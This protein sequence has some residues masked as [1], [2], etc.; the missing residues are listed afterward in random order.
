[1]AAITAVIFDLDD[2]LYDCTGVLV[3]AARRRAAEAMVK[4]GLPMTVEQAYQL[5]VKL[6]SEYGPRLNVFE[7]IAEI[8]EKDEYLVRV[9]LEAYNSSEISHDIKPFPDVIPTL[10][11]LRA[12]GY[13]LFIITSGVYSRQKRK[14]DILGLW[15]YVDDVLIN[16]LERGT[17]YEECFHEIL[18]KHHLMSK[19]VVCVGDRLHEEIRTGN[20]LGMTTVQMMHGRFRDVA[21]QSPV[22]EPDFRI[23]RISELPAILKRINRARSHE[24]YRV[25]AIGGGTGLPVVLQGLKHRTKNLTALVTV[26]DSGR[27]SGRLRKEMGVLPPGDIRN[28]LVALSQNEQSQK[29]LHDLFQ[30]RFRNG[31][32]EG[33]SLGNLFL[34]ALSE[35][36]GSF[37]KAVKEAGEI[38][39]IQGK[40]L[41]ST[42]RDCHVCAIL[43]DG[44]EV[45]EEFNVRQPGKP[46]IKRVFLEPEDAEALPEAVDEV[47]EADVIVLG[48]G[49]L[50]TSVISNLL[51]KGIPE[52]I[53]DSNAKVIYV[54]NIVTQPGQTD[55]YK[56]SD[57]VKAV[58]DYLHPAELDLVLVN[59]KIPPR[60]VI[61]RYRSEGAELVEIDEDLFRLDVRVVTADL[62]EN[63]QG[64][65]I[66]WEKADLLRHDPEKLAELI[67]KIEGE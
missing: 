53:R 7:K 16:D 26:T 5:Q 64:F 17:S 46:P 48:P 55:G 11:K 28:C 31:S 33:M 44:R 41:P 13:K 65:R 62:I 57:H 30:F 42:L 54:C 9:A 3:D 43:S 51:V 45:R 8:Y 60:E 36:T 20:H 18:L 52:A 1:M 27:S 22:E 56:A 50:Y 58:M 21:P 25:V 49:S 23:R 29:R 15:Q 35:I 47:L 66:L 34:V 6:A 59:S 14:L 38:F 40:V 4:A 2:T 63:I 19:E 10:R 12:L 67:M 37:E 61:E 24:H 32:L 39:A